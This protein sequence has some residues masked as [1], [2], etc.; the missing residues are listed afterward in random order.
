[1]IESPYTR[2]P[3]NRWRQRGLIRPGDR[4]AGHLVHRHEGLFRTQPVGQQLRQRRHLRRILVRQVAR[5]ADVGVQVKK[6]QL[7]ARMVIDELPRSLA[8]GAERCLAAVV[9]WEVPDKGAVFRCFSF[10]SAARS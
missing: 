9:V 3:H 5:L 2:H 4:L 6:L 8:D 1:M 7:L 10:S